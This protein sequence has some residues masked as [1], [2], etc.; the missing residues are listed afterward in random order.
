MW[1]LTINVDI[2]YSTIVLIIGANPLAVV[3][4]PKADSATLAGGKKQ[5][6][7][8]VVLHTGQRT[9]V[10]LEQNRPHGQWADSRANS[11]KVPFL[12]CLVVNFC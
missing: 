4:V 5:V 7:I 1:V 8:L 11:K 12:F 6:T 10:A 3:T 9:I 2:H